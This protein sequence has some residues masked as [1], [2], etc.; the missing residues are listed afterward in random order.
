RGGNAGAGS[1]TVLATVL[2]DGG[3]EREPLSDAARSLLDGHI[4]LASSLARAG[5]YPA[6]DV[7]ESTSRTMA[8]VV[9]PA[10]ARDAAAV[11]AAL[12]L[13]TATKDARSVGLSPAPDAAL[14]AA[15]EA[16]PALEAFLRQDEPAAIAETQ[17]ALTTLATAVRSHP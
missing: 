6:I 1:V 9:S 8:D 5:H 3:D 14:D 17:R 4:V 16:E 7:L 2:S 11:R 13:L 15:L 12:A 10:H